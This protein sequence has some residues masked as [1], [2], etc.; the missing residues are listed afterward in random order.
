MPQ[1]IWMRYV[2]EAQGTKV[3]DNFVYQ[4]NKSEIKMKKNGRSSNGKRTWHINIG[5]YFVTD[6]IQ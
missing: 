6:H 3:S 5:Y 1:I 2:L 4:E